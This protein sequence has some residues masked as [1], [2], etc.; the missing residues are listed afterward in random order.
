MGFWNQE[1]EASLDTGSKVSEMRV[2]F[3]FSTKASPFSAARGPNVSRT[4]NPVY[5]RYP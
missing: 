1:D 2:K 3:I 5:R 4:L